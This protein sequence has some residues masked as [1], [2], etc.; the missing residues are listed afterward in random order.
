L[1]TQ[2]KNLHNVHVIIQALNT[3]SLHQHYEDVNDDHKFQFFHI[4]F[5]EKYVFHATIDV[6][7]FINSLR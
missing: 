7:Q 2:F 3:T 6:H 5:I 4:F 1:K